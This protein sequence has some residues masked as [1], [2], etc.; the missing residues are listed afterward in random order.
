MLFFS[1]NEAKKKKNERS[2]E[3]FTIYTMYRKYQIKAFFR[4]HFLYM[5]LQE[6]NSQIWHIIQQWMLLLYVYP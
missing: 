1:M 4:T 2:Q 6:I 5:Y 3:N